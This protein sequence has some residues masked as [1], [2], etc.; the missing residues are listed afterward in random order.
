MEFNEAECGKCDAFTVFYYLHCLSFTWTDAIFPHASSRWI[1]V[2]SV[3]TSKSQMSIETTTGIDMSVC[4][5][6]LFRYHL[7][8]Q[9]TFL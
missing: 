1:R 2:E 4:H 9:L 6:F 8:R 7:I 3:R 5:F